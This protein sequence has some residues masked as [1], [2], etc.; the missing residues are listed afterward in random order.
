MIILTDKA[1]TDFGL[2][3]F[4]RRTSI[5][6]YKNFHKLSETAQYAVIV[7]WFDSVGM[8]IQVGTYN[9]NSNR[10]FALYIVNFDGSN[11]HFDCGFNNRI[12]TTKGAI[13]VANKIYNER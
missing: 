8:Y 4:E 9:D 6:E 12:E 10:Q 3:H 7:E 13:I 2:W 1:K 11:S 5:A